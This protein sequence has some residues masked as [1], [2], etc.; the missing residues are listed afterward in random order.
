MAGDRHWGLDWEDK[1]DEHISALQQLNCD[2]A[3]RIDA[4]QSRLD[5][6]HVRLCG[7]S[8]NNQHPSAAFAKGFLVEFFPQTPHRSIPHVPCDQKADDAR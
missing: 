3:H 2:A 7:M 1:A 6:I 8:E 5:E 4:L